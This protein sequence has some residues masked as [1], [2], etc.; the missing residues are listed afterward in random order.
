MPEL[1]GNGRIKKEDA[2][3]FLSQAC[4][5]RG[6]E[7]SEAAG[8]QVVPRVDL[9]GDR[10]AIKTMIDARSICRLVVADFGRGKRTTA[11][12]ISE[13]IRALPGYLEKL[14]ANEKFENLSDM[15]ARCAP[16]ST[17]S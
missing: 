12:D 17:S 1:Q 9:S 7:V 4:L 14:V 3:Y 15:L 2:V 5:Q 8:K 16:V 11:G 10:L 13:V 6:R